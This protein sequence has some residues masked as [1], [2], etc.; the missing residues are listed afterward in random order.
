MLLK[1]RK[2]GYCNALQ[3]EAAQCH[4]SHSPLLL[5]HP[6]LGW[7]LSIYPF[8]TWNVFIAYTLHLLWPWTFLV[9]RLWCDQLLYQILAKWNN[10]QLSYSDLK[11]E[12]LELTSTLDFTVGGFQSLYDLHGPVTHPHTK[13]ERNWT[14]CGWSF[15]KFVPSGFVVWRN[16]MLFHVISSWPG[17]VG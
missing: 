14:I 16:A 8:L 4:V 5:R 9:Y 1:T 13:F 10:P 15:I 7:S 17:F 3:L 6:Y 12:K 11:I 2:G